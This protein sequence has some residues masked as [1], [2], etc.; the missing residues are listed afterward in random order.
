MKRIIG[1]ILYLIAFQTVV[2]AFG[3]KIYHRIALD[4]LNTKLEYLEKNLKK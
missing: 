3:G 2:F 4:K 1:L